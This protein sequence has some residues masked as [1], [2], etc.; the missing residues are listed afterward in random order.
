ME[1]RILLVAGARPN[2][3]KVAPLVWEL[4]RRPEVRTLLVHTGQHYDPDMSEPSFAIWTWRHR[5]SIWGWDRR[6]MP[7]RRP[8]S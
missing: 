4:R 6:A 3:M 2:F 7:S 1:L 8:V 5:T